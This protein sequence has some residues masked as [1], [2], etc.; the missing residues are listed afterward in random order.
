M[1]QYFPGK[2]GIFLFSK[3]RKWSMWTLAWDPL[4]QSPGNWISNN[5]DKPGRVNDLK[6]LDE[7]MGFWIHIRQPNVELTIRG[8][9]PPS[10]SIALNTGWNRLGYPSSTIRNRTLGSNN[11]KSGT[12]VD[13]IQWY[14]ASTGTRHFLGPD[15]DFVPGRGYWMYSKVDTTWEV[16][17]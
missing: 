3:G 2:R 14:D 10:D 12:E 4:T 11:L 9:I 17:V 1:N 6:N 16:P 13:V 15:D 8:Y 5:I 7:K